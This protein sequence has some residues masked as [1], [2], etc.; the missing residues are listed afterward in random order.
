M[1]DS[2]PTVSVVLPVKNPHPEYFPAA[3][4]SILG[5][6]HRD[7]QL[8]IIEAPS[9]RPAGALLSPFDDARIRHI[10]IHGPTTLVEQLNHGLELSQATFVARMDADDIARAD[11]IEK[12]LQFLEQHPEVDVLGS[13]LEVIDDTGR[14]VG[15][16]KYPR[17][18]EAILAAMR[19]FN[20]LAH[21]AV[22]VRRQAI[23]DAGGYRHPERAAQDYELWSRLARG[24]KR[25][26]NHEERLLQYRLHAEA[27]KV[28]RLRDT[29]RSTI[30]TKQTYWRD[31][32]NWGDR[33]R[34]WLERMALHAPA[35]LVLWAFQKQAYQPDTT[36]DS[37]E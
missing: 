15:V 30:E 35:A 32:M 6:S 21:P 11:R 19:R 33:G 36:G 29:I 23:V 7:L 2:I 16:R 8:L 4:E 27:V 1:T 24:G 14:T 3:V 10:E 26:A 13:Q 31:T 9:D 37:P 22:M 28:A 34:M 18:H 25:F 12:Q 20:P 5:Q 17:D